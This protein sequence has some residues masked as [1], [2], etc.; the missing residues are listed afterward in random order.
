MKKACVLILILIAWACNK[1]MA[2]DRLYIQVK[3]GDQEHPEKPNWG[4]KDGMIIDYVDELEW[5]GPVK[6]SDHTLKVFAVFEVDRSY[7]D[8]IKTYL[9]TSGNDVDDVNYK[10]RKKKLNLKRTADSLG[11]PTLEIKWRD[12]DAVPIQNLK[13]KKVENLI[14]DTRL[15]SPPQF[16]FNSVAAGSYTIGNGGDYATL[17]AFIAD[18]AAS[19]TGNLTGT[20]I[21]DITYTSAAQIFTNLSG[22][23]LL[24]TGD[25]THNG[26][27]G[28]GRFVNV[29]NVNS[30]ILVQETAGQEGK[31]EFKDFSFKIVSASTKVLFQVTQVDTISFHDI[32]VDGDYKNGGSGTLLDFGH[33]SLRIDVGQFYNLS[34]W[35]L[36][37]QDAINIYDPRITVNN[38]VIGCTDSACFKEGI[39]CRNDSANIYNTFVYNIKDG[40]F[41]GCANAVGTRNACDDATCED[42]DFLVG[43]SNQPSLTYANEIYIDDASSNFHWP[44]AGGNIKAGGL[45]THFSATDIKGSTWDASSPSIGA[46]QYFDPPD[47]II[48]QAPDSGTTDVALDSGL[49][50][51]TDAAADSFR[52]QIATDDGFASMVIDTGAITDTVFSM[53]G[54]DNNATYYWRAR[55]HGAGGDGDW[56]NIWP[57]VTVAAD[58]STASALTTGRAIMR[59]LGYSAR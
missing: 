37:T 59:R 16:D 35:D 3:V 33:T 26:V 11:N 4:F 52:L 9:E 29:N 53:S 54:L 58:T 31:V 7:K 19:L 55:G 24:I 34:I 22:Y 47:A 21:S 46:F 25:T 51:Y 45:T 48:L 57:F 5:G 41:G 38:M 13:P 12:N 1:S 43:T 14:E 15:W 32:F 27:Y 6:F 18:I 39:D 28:T 2:Q 40:A 50:W 17:E 56:S 20:I 23:R 49:W 10:Q 30:S 44:K 8:L 42:A 36:N